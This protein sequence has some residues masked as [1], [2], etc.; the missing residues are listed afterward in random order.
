MDWPPL[1]EQL[2]GL[3]IPF[4]MMYYS[5]GYLLRNMY[6]TYIQERN[7]P[8]HSNFSQIKDTSFSEFWAWLTAPVA[9]QEPPSGSALLIPGIIAQARGVVLDIGPGSGAQVEF[10][11]NLPAVKKIYGAEPSTGLHSALR[12]RIA[13]AGLTDKY[14]VLPCPA[15]KKAILLNLAKAGVNTQSEQLFDTV[16]CV[17]VLCSVPKQEAAA[18]ELYSMLKPGGQLLIVEHVIYHFFGWPFFLGGCEMNRNTKATLEKIG[19]WESIDI[20]TSF[21]WSVLPWL[22]GRLVK[23]R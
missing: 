19:D 22:N 8:T 5:A 18:R 6:K 10:F 1:Q 23:K 7:F 16:I 20:K 14:H 21:G 13:E 9:S 15:E 3:I 2:A 17:R 4:W 12:E 11:K